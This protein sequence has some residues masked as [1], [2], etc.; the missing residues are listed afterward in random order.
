MFFNVLDKK[1]VQMSELVVWSLNCGRLVGGSPEEVA[2]VLRWLMSLSEPDAELPDVL[3]LQDFRVS[4][5]Q[6]LRPLPH[7]H[8]A[9]MTNHLIWGKRELVGICIASRYPLND[10]QI[11]HTWGDGVV[12]DLKGVNERNERIKPDAEADRLVLETENRVVIAA[13]VVKPDP[14]AGPG[15]LLPARIVT[16]HGFWVRGGVPTRE[17]LESTERLCAFLVHQSNSFGDC[18]AA[19][20]WNF[21]RDGKVLSLLAESGGMD[22]LPKSVQTTLAPHHPGAKFGAK[23]DRVITWTRGAGSW[24]RYRS[25]SLSVDFS[26]GSDHGMLCATMVP[27]A[28]FN[29]T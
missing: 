14:T 11:C 13:T 3:C 7:F 16:T 29:P 18:I 24:H 9:P 25:Q 1:E 21:D 8:F 19:A 26:P 27:T 10:I 23:P 22:W 28:E 2:P 12:R 5:L 17:Q 15:R 6:Y 4:L 20:D